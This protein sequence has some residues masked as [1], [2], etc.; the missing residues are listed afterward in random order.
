MKK[1]TVILSMFSILIFSGCSSKQQVNALPN[2]QIDL[3]QEKTYEDIKKRIISENKDKWVAIGFERAKKSLEKYKDKINSYEV[4]KYALR[5]GYVTYPQI[6]SVEENGQVS[7]Q[8]FGCEIRKEL[9]I[10]EIMTIFAND[11]LQVNNSNAI[12]S[13]GNINS[14]GDF[15]GVGVI[16]TS[17]STNNKTIESTSEF[18][19]AFEKRFMNSFKNKEQLDK[20][21]VSYLRSGAELIANFKNNQEYSNFC[22]MSEICK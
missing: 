6:L 7:I 14:K 2:G 16:E 12:P 20:Y 9:S 19:E 5:K 1:I 18:N 4:G 8:N 15:D 11:S 3:M 21:N 22:Q 17:Y 13:Y 10:D